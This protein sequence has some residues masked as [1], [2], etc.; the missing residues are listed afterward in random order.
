MRAR[1]SARQ[2][3]RTS[4]APPPPE[5]QGFLAI[6]RGDA[7]GVVAAPELYI[8]GDIHLKGGEGADHPFVRFLGGLAERPRARLVI[9]GDLF[10]YW[11]E[12]DGAVARYATVLGC[13]TRLRDA[14]WRL[15]LVRGNREAVAGRRLAVASGCALHWPALEVRLGPRRIRVVHGDRL[16]FDPGYRMLAAWLRLFAFRAWQ[17]CHPAAIQELVAQQLRRRSRGQPR[18]PVNRAG[19]PRVFIDRRRVQ[20]AGRE[21][22]TVVA[23]HVHQAWRRTIGGVDLMLVGDWP[24]IS[25]RWIEGFADGTLVG[26]AREFA[27]RQGAR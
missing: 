4:A 17:S 22:D 26:V 27:P 10:E 24:G 23:G 12:S 14:G 9:L 11:L 21:V 19:R 20:A 3:P 5:D 7:P 13:L 15:D 1:A 6:P 8:V 25:G 18:P 2:R 16:C